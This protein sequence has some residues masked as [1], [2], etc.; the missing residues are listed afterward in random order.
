MK[1]LRVLFWLA[2]LA[3]SASAQVRGLVVREVDGSPRGT[4]ITEI[5]VSNTTLTING[6]RAIITTGGGGGT[7][8][9]SPTEL[10]RNNAGAFGGIS[11]ATSDGTNVT[12][13]SGNLRAT[14]PR[15]TTDISDS[16]GNELF[17]LTATTSAVNEFTVANAATGNSPVLSAT[18]GDTNIGIVLTPKGSGSVDIQNGTTASPFYW[19]ATYTS[20]SNYRR[21]AFSQ[22]S[23]DAIISL[24]RSTAS[25]GQLYIRNASGGGTTIEA[26]TGGT[27]RASLATTGVFGISNSSGTIS[28]GFNAATTKVLG[29]NDSSTTAGA[30]LRVVP[31][32][33][34]QLTV[35][36]NNYQAGS[37]R[38]LFY[39]LSSDASRNLTGFNPA[40]GTNQDGEIHYFINVGSNNIVLVNESASSTAA[41]RFA[42]STGADI[43]LA[44]NEAALLVYDNTSA[45]W[46]VFKQ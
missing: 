12:F 42:N 38:S 11:G 34:T 44:A 8:G 20:L 40:G 15:F 14:S 46:R 13:G 17:K 5:V 33:P 4:G 10:Q 36:Q 23:S 2:L 30:T 25:G 31:D 22:S 3:V 26:T 39:R 45:R 7:P 16:N 9:G 21:I 6:Q 28:A 1:S 29:I 32:S 19:Y 24:E 43:T 35:D 37:G 41:N 18:G 27:W